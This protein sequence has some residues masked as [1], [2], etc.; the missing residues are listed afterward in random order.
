MRLF[1]A[2]R[3]FALVAALLV[4]LPARA[5]AANYFCKYQTSPSEIICVEQGK[6]TPVFQYP[7]GVSKQFL[8]FVLTR[9]SDYMPIIISSPEGLRRE[10]EKFRKA[11]EG[12]RNK[13][14]ALRSAAPNELDLYFEIIATYSQG[15]SIY[16]EALP[17]YRQAIKI[18]LAL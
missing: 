12:A 5:S 9:N 1:V 16:H 18:K 15:I 17:P 3:F 10:L 6:A 4:L 13:A 11:L 14:E 8:T 7:L 2:W